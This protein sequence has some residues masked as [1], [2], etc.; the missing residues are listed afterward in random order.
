MLLLG[1]PGTAKSQVRP[2]V[3]G[4]GAGQA[5]CMA[6]RACNWCVLA[7]TPHCRCGAPRSPP[8]PQPAHS[9]S[10]LAH[11]LP[12]LQFLKYIEKVAH[13]AVYTTGKGASAVGLTAAV[14]KDAITGEWTLE[15]GALV[16]A[17][18]VGG[19]AGELRELV[20]LVVPL[21]L[22]MVAEDARR[23]PEQ[24]K[25]LLLCQCEWQPTGQPARQAATCLRH[26]LPLTPHPCPASPRLPSRP[27]LPLPPG[28]VPD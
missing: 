11:P 7:H 16:L 28:R 5:G 20:L 22:R 21:R 14:H 26:G 24:R 19:R 27:A 9:V 12:T 3:E 25:G 18:R 1:D 13:R 2:Q 15:G 4:G 23:C 17:D 10:L 6:G 8:P